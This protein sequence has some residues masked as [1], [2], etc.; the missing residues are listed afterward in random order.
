MK[1]NNK[2]LSRRAKQ[3]GVT[4]V[5]I[6]VVLAIILALAAAGV[7][8]FQYAKQRS[9]V[10]SIMTARNNAAASLTMLR[11][12]P[13]FGGIIPLTEGA[14]PPV[15]AS[16]T[17][18]GAA[19]GAAA[20]AATLEMVLIT[21]GV[22]ESPYGIAAGTDRGPTN[23][24]AAPLLWSVAN[25][26]FDMATAG[27]PTQDF[28]AVRALECR[29]SNNA[30]AP[31]AAAGANFRLN[32]ITELDSNLRV[33]YW[34]IP[35]VAAATARAA[36]VAAFKN[37]NIPA[38]GLANNAGPVVYGAAVDGNTDVYVYVASF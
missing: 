13:G 28:T 32:G 24:T 4:L 15:T 3:R 20:N 37:G 38:A 29:I 30:L 23:P 2:I 26:A 6:L 14:A 17:N 22:Q 5:E 31:S 9:D 16:V 18:P 11:E 19:G 10:A 7:P 36:A 35:S 34:R 21:E 1:T 33:V 25:Q 27:T 12:K 8:A